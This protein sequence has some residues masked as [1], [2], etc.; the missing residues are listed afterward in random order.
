[1]VQRL[2]TPTLQTSF[3]AE[4]HQLLLPCFPLV[5][6]ELLLQRF[7]RSLKLHETFHQCNFCLT[8]IGLNRVRRDTVATSPTS[9]WSVKSKHRDTGVGAI[10]SRSKDVEEVSCVCSTT[11]KQTMRWSV[12]TIN[13]ID[14]ESASSNNCSS[15]SQQV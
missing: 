6:E 12:R 2:T 14:R 8:L 13:F 1:M 7:H 3:L 10:T 4:H 15:N 11:D 5:T 9:M